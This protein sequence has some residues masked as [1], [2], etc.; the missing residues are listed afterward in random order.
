MITAILNGYKR[1]EYLETQLNAIKGQTVKPEKI[2]LW[3]NAGSEF[4]SDI[5]DGITHVKSNEN[6]GVWARFAFAL[7]ATTEYICIFDDDTI[8]SPKWFENCLNTIKTNNGLLGAIGVRFKSM[9]SYQP[10]T[11]FGWSDNHNINTVEVDIV[12]HAWF[13]RREWLS[14]FWRELPNTNDSKLVGEDMHFS[15]MLQ[16]YGNIKTYVPPHPPNDKSL[17]GGNLQLGWQM[18]TDKHAISK[19]IESLD[20]MNKA[21]V[22]NINN[23][24]KPINFK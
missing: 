16:K 24:F 21:Y 3:Q 6:F 2:M 18:G 11:R 13:F 20:H 4:S 22:N 14:Y 12:G 17:W 10:I 5:T 15:F 9:N 7:N 23:G 8:P 1:P 19:N